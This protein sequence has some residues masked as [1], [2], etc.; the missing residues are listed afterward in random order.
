[1]K[2]LKVGII[3][4]GV[5]GSAI[6]K[7]IQ[8]DFSHLAEARYLCENN[9]KKTAVLLAQKNSK[10]KLVPLDRLIE[11]SD[12]VIEAASASISWDIARKSLAKGK[13]VMILSVAGLLEHVESMRRL[14]RSRGK[15][16]IPSGALAGIDGVLG[17]R[18]A[19]I[20]KAQLIMKKPPEGLKAAPYFRTRKF[21]NLRGDEK[22][23]VFRGSA[24]EAAQVFPQNVNVAAI[25]SLAGIGPDKTKV[26]VWTSRAY[27]RNQH[28]VMVQGKSGRMEFKICNVPSRF[29][30]R[31]SAQTIYSTIATLRKIFSPLCIGT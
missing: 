19:G 5:I 22:R 7:S 30:P 17:A 3:G 10:V 12:L 6:L 1:M 31:T 24:R 23:C 13:Q 9:P 14:L 28:A 11:R 29:N 26:E 27:R 8:E 18:E 15:L 21:P 16:W 2:R 25:L 20:T 4:Y